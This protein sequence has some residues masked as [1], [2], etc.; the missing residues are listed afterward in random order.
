MKQRNLA[1][2]LVGL[3]VSATVCAPHVTAAPPWTM[4]DV[5]GMTLDN[6]EAAFAEATEGVITLELFNGAGNTV[7][8]NKT[9]WEICNQSPESGTTLTAESWAGVGINRPGDC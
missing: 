3:C 5:S 6:A 4:P 7:V 2:A 8:Y 9:N 1:I